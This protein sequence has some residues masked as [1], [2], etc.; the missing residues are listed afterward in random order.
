MAEEEDLRDRASS[1]S[2]SSSSSDGGGGGGGDSLEAAEPEAE[3]GWTLDDCDADEESGGPTADLLLGREVMHASPAE[4]LA[5]FRQ[6]SGWPLDETFAS[7]S[8]LECVRLVNYLRSAHSSG[9]D[10]FTGEPL[11]GRAFADAVRE[12]AHGAAG[13]G[14]PAV[15]PAALWRGD[16]RYLAAAIEG[17][18]MVYL[19]MQSSARTDPEN[20]DEEE[21]EAGIAAVLPETETDEMFRRAAYAAPLVEGEPSDEED[22]RRRRRRRRRRPSGERR[23]PS[24]S[25]SYFESYSRFSIHR[26]MLSDAPRT[27]AYQRAIENN[28]SLI[29]GRRVLDVGCGSGILSL[30]AARAGAEKVLA[31]DGSGKMARLARAA[32]ASNGYAGAVEVLHG[33]VEALPS[34]PGGPVDVLVSEWMG[35][36][37]LFEGMLDSV[38]RARDKFLKPGGAM[39]PD[40]ATMLVA[41]GGP[42]TSSVPFWS[43]VYGFDLSCIGR[44]VHGESLHV[45]VVAPVGS[46]DIVTGEATLRSYDLTVLR[47]EDV[48]FLSEEFS[49]ANADGAGTAEVHTLVLWFDVGFSARFCA[50]DEVTLS[51]SPG[52]APTHWAQTVLHLREP[53]SLGPGGSVRGVASV[54]RSR[55][56]RRSIDISVRVR[57]YTAEGQPTGGEQTLIYDV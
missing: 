33:D 7:L 57:G 27:R 11:N 38:I 55:E 3:D 30:F 42:G 6:E 44:E 28:P 14:Q 56:S 15:P 35:Y 47:E 52:S 51:T 19:A 45:G 50:E 21:E 1:A 26:E 20:D 29:R 39:L 24:P 4:A 12:A 49:L 8:G 18:P 48:G 23:S 40:R 17:D 22:P 2:S 36:A 34:L 43:D 16:D 46:A 25:E 31:I 54:S 5:H 41:G 9:M 13:G 53:I 10:P 32:V 37:L